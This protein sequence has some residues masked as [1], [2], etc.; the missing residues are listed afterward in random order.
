MLLDVPLHRQE[1]PWSCL[2]ACVRIRLEF[3][4][5]LVDE[6]EVIRAC[7]GSPLGLNLED[8]AL[9][10][11]LLGF[12]STILHRPDAAFVQEQL[13]IEQPVIVSLSFGQIANRTLRHAVVVIGWSPSQVCIVDPTDGARSSLGADHFLEYWEAGGGRGMVIFPR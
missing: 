11:H 10:L 4:G 6:A 13:A 3:H 1:R 7:G 9:G 12:D 2:A 5:S 8:T